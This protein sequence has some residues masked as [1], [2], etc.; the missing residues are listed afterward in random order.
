MNVAMHSGML[1]TRVRFQDY[2]VTHA[3]D[4][5]ITSTWSDVT[6]VSG[7]VEPLTGAERMEADRPDSFRTKRLTVRYNTT[8]AGIVPRYRVVIGNVVHEIVSIVETKNMRTELVLDL[9]EIA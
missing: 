2:T 7:Y 5:G 4:G 8:T 9:R 6:T 1:R 3:A